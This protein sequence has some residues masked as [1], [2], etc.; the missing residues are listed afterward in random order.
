MPSS[1]PFL[2]TAVAAAVTLPVL[3]APANAAGSAPQAPATAAARTGAEVARSSVSWGRCRSAGLRYSGM[4]CATV[5]TPMDAT[6]PGGPKVRIAVSRITHTSSQRRYLGVVLL[7][8]GGPGG[9]GLDLPAIS[10]DLPKRVRSRYDWIGFDPRGVGMS[11]P[12]VT[13]DRDY[14][15]FDRPDYLPRPKA[16]LRAWLKRSEGYADDCAKNGAILEHM[17]TTDSVADMEAIRQALG[18]QRINYLGF[19]YGTYLGQVYAT[20]H[21]DR[22]DRMILDS[23]VDPQRVFY[24]A[25]L[26]QDVAMQQN[27]NRWFAWIAKR[28]GTFELGRTA[29]AVTAAFNRT[30]R[31]LARKPAKGKI[32]SAEWIDIFTPVAYSTDAWFGLAS[33]FSNYV[34]RNDSSQLVGAYREV[35]GN[36]DNSFAVY[37]AVQCTDAPWPIAWSTWSRDN[38]RVFRK[39][40]NITWMNA[41]FNAQCRYWPAAAGP[42]FE[43]NGDQAP[44]TLLVGGTYDGATPFPGS[45]VVRNLFP[46]SVLVEV[47]KGVNHANALGNRCA[48]GYISRFL[49]SGTLPVR[50]S[51]YRADVRCPLV[52]NGRGLG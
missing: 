31:K 7:N 37:S 23:N 22:V 11:R 20:L 25:N 40:P 30:D 16:N 46:R 50:K 14:F 52:G 38:W 45:L 9:A 19:S 24:K 18:A 8:P 36:D 1:H 33:V 3:A 49:G 27:L 42:R 48:R 15:G 4:K 26:D 2:I 44:A 32:G 47:V 6:R 28:N 51:G 17:R 29:K 35:V 5:T 39:A 12:R 41:W 43:V 34:N 13:C 21:P 10:Q